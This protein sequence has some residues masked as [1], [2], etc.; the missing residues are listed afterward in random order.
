MVMSGVFNTLMKILDGALPFF[1][2][3]QL[4]ADCRLHTM[5]PH[6][7]F[8]TLISTSVLYA[9]RLSR[10]FP[11][12]AVAAIR[13]AGQTGRAR[14][15]KFKEVVEEVRKRQ[16][17]LGPDAVR[18]AWVKAHVGTQGSEKADQIRSRVGR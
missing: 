3:V 10:A 7:C 12:A 15:G 9:L 17:N 13:K 16:K 18:F 6:L 11:R 2:S 8:E 14:T 1:N 4:S 5:I